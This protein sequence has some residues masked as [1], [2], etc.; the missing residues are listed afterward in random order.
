M[1]YEPRHVD[2]TCKIEEDALFY[3]QF[4]SLINVSMYIQKSTSWWWI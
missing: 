1:G 2:A 4:I 3:S